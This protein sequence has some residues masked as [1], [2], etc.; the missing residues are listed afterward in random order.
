MQSSTFRCI[1]PQEKIL[2]DAV[3]HGVHSRATPMHSVAEVTYTEEYTR[4]T[5]ASQTREAPGVWQARQEQSSSLHVSTGSSPPL[6]HLYRQQKE[7]MLFAAHAEP[8]CCLQ[9]ELSSARACVHQTQGQT[10]HQ[11]PLRCHWPL[12][13]YQV[14]LPPQ[15]HSRHTAAV[16]C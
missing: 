15:Q 4:Y 1:N 10:S 14:P 13:R 2:E 3:L 16:L 11:V 12:C 7:L 8:P 6:L 5:D 9:W